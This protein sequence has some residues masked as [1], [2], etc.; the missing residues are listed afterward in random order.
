[1]IL[2]KKKLNNE[3]INVKKNINKKANTCNKT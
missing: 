3:L 1:M 2:I